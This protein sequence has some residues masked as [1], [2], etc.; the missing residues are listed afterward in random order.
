MAT[1]YAFATAIV[2]IML[3][4][5]TYICSLK[6]FNGQIDKAY[7]WKIIR[8]NIILSSLSLKKQ[9]A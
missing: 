2:Y 9:T 7:Q 8:K 6:A 1:A 5:Y 4:K 3:E